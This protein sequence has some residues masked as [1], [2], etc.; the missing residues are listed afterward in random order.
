M[1]KSVTVTVR[2]RTSGDGLDHTDVFTTTN[3][4]APQSYLVGASAGFNGPWAS[5]LFTGMSG[6][7]IVPPNSQSGQPTLSGVSKTLKG[8]SPDTGIPLD[9]AAVQV[10]PVAAGGGGLGLTFSAPENV[11]LILF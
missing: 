5:G 9:P 8:A 3:A 10:I 2:V 4:A 11:Y 7:V 1:S 6:A